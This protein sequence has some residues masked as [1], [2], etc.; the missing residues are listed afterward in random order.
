MELFRHQKEGVEF[1]KSKGKAILADEMG[2]GK[3]V[4]AIMAAHETAKGVLVVCQASTKINWKRE[5]LKALPG[6]TVR[7]MDTKSE[8][9]PCPRWHVINYDILEKKMA[10]LEGMIEEGKIDTM[11]LDESQSIKGKSL[12]AACIVG[13][14]F[15]P[16]GKA[17]MKIPGIASKVGR[18]YCLTGTPIMNRPIELF[19]QLRAIGHPLAS[20]RSAFAKRY[21]GAFTMVQ[22]LNLATGRKFMTDQTKAYSYY[23]DRTK[24]RH[25]MRFLNEQG[26]TNLTE[27][28]DKIKESVL[29]RKKKEVMDLPE[30]IVSTV[31]CEMTDEWRKAYESAWDAYI[32][33]VKKHVEDDEKIENIISAR[34]LVEIQKLKQVASL[35][36]VEK[37]VEDV[38]RA[39]ESEAKVIIFS[40]YT[41][42]IRTICAR[43]ANEGIRNVSLTGS[44]DMDAR[45]VAIDGFQSDPK[46]QAFVANIKAGGV[47]ITLTAASIVMFADMEWSPEIHHQ[48]EDRAHRIGQEG[49]V[50]VYYYVAE[51]TI[52]RHIIEVLEEKKS[53]IEEVIDGTKKRSKSA[54][55][56]AEVARRM[57]ERHVD[58]A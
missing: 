16:K 56:Q 30:K 34:Q 3:S 7:I 14:T 19:N 51:D 57:A 17:K 24:F 31:E 18:V 6:E 25:C 9:D 11:I 46:I 41:E 26:A 53:E 23:G 39:A 43:L 27:L 33:G 45:Q 22:V 13:G 55:V 54:S 40:Q 37:I 10:F 47:G 36:K 35:S 52:D 20:N 32:D 48:A 21:C 44:D 49:T 2:L 8:D 42:T 38:H 28:R 1:L 4:Q 50:N 5:I 15:T 12:R 58:R 29:R